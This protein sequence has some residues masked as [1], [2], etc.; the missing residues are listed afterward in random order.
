MKNIKLT[1][2]Y[3]GTNYLGYQYT[4][5]GPT[6]E[7]YLKEV[8]E[9]ILQQKVRL[10]AASRTDAG[11]HAEGQVVNFYLQKERCLDQLLKSLNQL[12]PK[13][14]RIFSI[15]KVPFSF[16]PT[17]DAIQKEYHY[18]IDTSF[19]QLP[20][21]RFFS[22][23][24]FTPLD[25]EKMKIAATYFLGNHNFD[26]FRNES[27]AKP[28]NT[29]CL[30]HRCDLIYEKKNIYFIICGNRFLYKMIRNLVG[31]LVFVGNGKLSLEEAKE[32]LLKKTRSLVGITAPAHGLILKKIFY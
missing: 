30:L 8:L 7:K 27:Y 10:Q 21:N 31:T 22:W 6:V 24:Y 17:L 26:S 25:L 12:L 28:K 9:K 29:F 15:E 1:L 13:D 23:H 14:I 5:E 18:C 32:L 2:S 4:K 3:E 11:V 20:F 16:H 19:V